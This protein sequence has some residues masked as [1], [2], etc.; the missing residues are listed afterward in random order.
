[1]QVG[2]AQNPMTEFPRDPHVQSQA[3]SVAKKTDTNRGQNMWSVE[4]AMSTTPQTACRYA[5]ANTTAL[6]RQCVGFFTHCETTTGVPHCRGGGKKV[7]GGMV[8]FE[9]P[10]P[11][12]GG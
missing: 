2:N 12:G 4:C 6:H 10:Y 5:M 9:P 7:C 8:S 3:M 11:G 1:M